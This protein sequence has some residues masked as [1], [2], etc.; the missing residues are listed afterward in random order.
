M[1]GETE[2][3]AKARRYTKKGLAELED[4]YASLQENPLFT[5]LVSGTQRQLDNPY[6][7]TP[8]LVESLKTN[9]R[10]NTMQGFNQASQGFRERAAASGGFR[11]GNQREG[12]RRLAQGLGNQLGQ[13]E[14]QIDTMVAMQNKQDERTALANVAPVLQTQYRYPDMIAAAQL[15]AASLPVWQQPSAGEA[16]YAGLG[17]AMM[18]GG[19]NAFGGGFGGAG[20][21]AASGAGG[22]FSQ[23]FGAS[24]VTGA[25]AGA[26]GTSSKAA[27]LL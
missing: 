11:G 25:G 6:T 20:G 15:G 7:F 19:K 23:G 17:N 13:N 1:G 22:F 2:G 27:V 14:R 21:S 9:S 4:A 18:A 3:Q 24:G 16:F 12:E 26:A 10:Q 8:E 5:G